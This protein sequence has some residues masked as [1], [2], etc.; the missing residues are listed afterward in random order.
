MEKDAKPGETAGGCA[1]EDEDAVAVE[2]P[3]GSSSVALSLP[4]QAEAEL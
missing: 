4:P 3:Q 2:A 1:V